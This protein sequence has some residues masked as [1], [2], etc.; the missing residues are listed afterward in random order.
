MSKVL[1]RAIPEDIVRGRIYAVCL[2]LLSMP[3][4]LEAVR[5]LD[6]GSAT[7][8]IIGVL[9]IPVLIIGLYGFYDPRFLGLQNE[10][11]TLVIIALAG[12]T[13]LYVLLVG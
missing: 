2:V 6:G 10:D 8:I 12:V 9:A 4:V 3:F 7:V 13:V 5:S 1:T 11:R